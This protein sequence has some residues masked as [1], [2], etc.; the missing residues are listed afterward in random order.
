MGEEEKIRKEI[1]V[2]EKEHKKLDDKIRF[3]LAKSR[4]DQILVQRLKRK[5]LQAKDRINWLYT[6]LV[7]DIIA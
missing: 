6:Q 7:E 1:S 3:L 5:K 2:L 4:F